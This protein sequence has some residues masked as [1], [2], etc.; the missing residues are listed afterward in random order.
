VAWK[1]L[2]RKREMAK[3]SADV[4]SQAA[5]MKGAN[6][7]AAFIATVDETRRVA[8]ELETMDRW[9]PDFD[10]HV[11][12]VKYL[13]DKAEREETELLDLQKEA[14]S[15]MADAD[16]ADA[17]KATRKTLIEDAFA[18]LSRNGM[19]LR[20]CRTQYSNAKTGKENSQKMVKP[21][22]VKMFSF[23]GK[24]REYVTFRNE[25]KAMYTPMQIADCQR[26]YF[27]RKA[28]RGDALLSI[29]R[30]E[31]SDAAY[32][33]AWKILEANYGD[34]T[35]AKHQI[36]D[37]LY[38]KGCRD[39]TSPRELRRHCDEMS[40]LFKK[41]FAIDPQLALEQS[42]LQPLC[43]KTFPYQLK[44]D[45]V[46]KLGRKSNSVTEFL[47]TARAVIQDEM[48]LQGGLST[49][50][51]SRGGEGKKFP[52]KSGSHGSSGKG[53]GSGHTMHGLAGAV[54]RNHKT[55]Q[56]Q[57]K[58]ASSPPKGAGGGSGKKSER[59]FTSSRGAAAAPL[60]KS[61]SCAH[62]KATHSIAGCETFKKLPLQERRARVTE[63]QLCFKCLRSG[64][65]IRDCKGGKKCEASLGKG[66]C[67][68]EKH[69]T[70]LHPASNKNKK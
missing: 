23:D 14:I 8:S 6:L 11:S 18:G 27:L 15:L 13:L 37:E 22:T 16:L 46:V 66:K 39:T 63:L 61:S 48:E 36:M 1:E 9:I 34:K 35:Q 58:K 38:G 60:G 57:K 32:G 17:D 19:E 12:Q 55:G 3:A 68:S 67:G 41:L 51:E 47:E 10:V 69:H 53:S 64:H 40:I 56:F 59:K 24:L 45:L 29:K 44:K 49:K 43:E 20:T 4:E 54:G 28:L 31:S 30:L 2:C 70:L 33:E 50:K 26:F 42:T 65:V 21:E 52:S 62:C 5:A 7:M 25:F